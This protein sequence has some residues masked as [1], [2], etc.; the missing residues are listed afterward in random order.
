MTVVPKEPE[1]YLPIWAEEIMPITLVFSV[2]LI[3]IVHE[4][5]ISIVVVKRKVRFLPVESH[6]PIAI[7]ISISI[8]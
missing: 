3:T 7:V 6:Q 5:I 8:K 2:Y 1:I 4:I